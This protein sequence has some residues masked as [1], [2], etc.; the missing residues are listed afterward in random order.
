MIATE[1][2]VRLV[3][4]VPT[5][6]AF[7]DATFT[8]AVGADG[9]R[10]ERDPDNWA[11]VRRRSQRFPAEAAIVDSQVLSEER[12]G[13]I[14]YAHYFLVDWE[15]AM[16][17]PQ[18]TFQEPP[19]EV[20]RRYAAGQSIELG[21]EEVALYRVVYRD[22]VEAAFE[23]VGEQSFRFQFSTGF[24]GTFWRDPDGSC[25]LK[26]KGDRLQPTEDAVRSQSKFIVSRCK[27]SGNLLLILQD[28]AT[29]FL[30]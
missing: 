4:C 30:S 1:L 18:L 23:R 15:D 9:V 8:V 17:L 25:T 2:Q 6:V 20:V 24:R 21:L 3:R 11:M 13:E 26:F 27:Y 28:D 16:S 10:V 14:D 12:R 5:V 7:D 29:V 22:A 19:R